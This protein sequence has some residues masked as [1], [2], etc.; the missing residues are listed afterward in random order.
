MTARRTKATVPAEQSDAVSTEVEAAEPTAA[1]SELSELNE[2][3]RATFPTF[4]TFVVPTTEQIVAESPK[5]TRGNVSKAQIAHDKTKVNVEGHLTKLADR[6]SAIVSFLEERFGIE[7]GL[8]E[9]IRDLCGDNSRLGQEAAAARKRESSFKDAGSMLAMVISDLTLAIGGTPTKPVPTVDANGNVV[10]TFTMAGCTFKLTVAHYVLTTSKLGHNTERI[11]LDSEGVRPT[12][13][14]KLEGWLS[15][16]TGDTGVKLTKLLPE[17][18]R[19]HLY[20][21]SPARKTANQVTE[22]AKIFGVTATGRTVVLGTYYSVDL[23]RLG[24][25]RPEEPRDW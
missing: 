10:Y 19:A 18:V 14:T 22:L 11:S 17:R 4:P 3:I 16:V 2:R 13:W 5:P 7:N 8:R 6:Y 23:S 1:W 15:R 9:Q 12:E 25:H 20:P 24:Y 21:A